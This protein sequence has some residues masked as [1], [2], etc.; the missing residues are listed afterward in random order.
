MTTLGR[1]RAA[2]L[3]LLLVTV[4]VGACSAPEGA[5]DASTASATAAGTEAPTPAPTATA[6]I[7]GSPTPIPSPTPAPLSDL[8]VG[9]L[10]KVVVTGINVRTE[11]TAS[12]PQ[13]TG[14]AGTKQ[15]L[16]NGQHVLVVGRPLWNEDHWWLLVGL[17]DSG[18]NAAAIAVGWVAGGTATEEWLVSDDAPC[19]T[20]TV[21]VLGEMDG[22][23]RIGC[24]DSAPLTI[25]AHVAAFPPDAG[26]GGVCA[27]VGSAPDWLVCDNVNDNWVNADGGPDW[28]LLLHFAPATGVTATGLAGEGTIGRAVRV[29]GHY[30]DPAAASCIQS[31][32][33]TNLDAQSQRLTCAAKFVVESVEGE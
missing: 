13:V 6:T 12:A 18:P 31:D 23:E 8:P 28:V 20:P 16:A 3:A 14:A 29:A 1:G 7:A 15:A 26:L 33:P 11:P 25:E 32:G 5:S 9:T 19:V 21:T 27:A 4:L 2:I 17:P 10:A 24:F 30:D 22:I